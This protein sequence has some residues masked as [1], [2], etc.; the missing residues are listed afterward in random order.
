MKLS[1][2]AAMI[3]TA[4]LS[5]C[6]VIPP[7]GAIPSRLDAKGAERMDRMPAGAEEWPQDQW[8]HRYR[9]PQLDGLVTAALAGSPSMALAAARFK[10]AEA[11]L[12]ASEA[13]DKVNATIS[14]NATR[15]R[16]P[17]HD[18][19]PPPLAG[20]WKNHGQLQAQAALEIDL[21]GR[22]RAAI[23][24]AVGERE[25]GRADRAE[26][27]R[28][29]VAAVAQGYFAWL[30]DEARWRVSQR[31]SEV[32]TAQTGLA[33]RRVAAGLD[34]VSALDAAREEL[35]VAKAQTEQL[36]A[37]RLRDREALRALVGGDARH[38]ESLRVRSLPEPAAGLPATLG[39]HLLSRRPD[40]VAA[41]WR[42][43][44]AVQS[45]K[46]DEAA[47]YPDVNLTGFF[48]F[49]S[50]GL[51]NLLQASSRGPGMSAAFSLPLFDS[52]R[53]RSRLGVSRAQRDAAIA[54][55]NQTLVNAVQDVADQGLAWRGL[56]RQKDEQT[57][58]LAAADRQ[59]QAAVR[60]SASGLADRQT[61][62]RAELPV[63]K[64]HDQLLQVN[65]A[66]LLADVA[67][68]KALGGGY[69][70]V[71]PSG[72]TTSGDTQ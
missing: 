54:Q 10:Q 33:Q 48:G 45:V 32:L 41:K 51:E 2:L 68:T 44:A 55:Y 72:T 24:S 52:G 63:L 4:W 36:D 23:A 59:R 15:Q 1:P 12:L 60:R 21:W 49:N 69:H 38:I 19:Y 57:R 27:A 71:S 22:N 39:L 61:T 67:L 11:R 3:L 17:E 58:A 34:P 20:S 28:V 5:A 14:G 35:A 37:Q 62:L 9:D 53:L 42:V 26:A 25:A 29:L 56:S 43:E 70:A 47:F 40:L 30:A 8:W 65:K 16:Y 64:E 7:D 13:S 6:A 66:M 50:I 31:Q 18:I 46:S